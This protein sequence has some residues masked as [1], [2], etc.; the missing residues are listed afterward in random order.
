MMDGAAQPARESAMGLRVGGG[1]G[2]VGRPPQAV[3]GLHGRGCRWDG[4]AAGGRTRRMSCAVA[5]SGPSGHLLWGDSWLAWTLPRSPAGD[6]AR[7]S[8]HQASASSSVKW[9]CAGPAR[10]RRELR[11]VLL[12]RGLVHRRQLRGGCAS[13]WEAS[14]CA[15]RACSGWETSTLRCEEPSVA[16]LPSAPA[17]LVTNTNV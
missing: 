15:G 16:E 13:H 11:E 7:S 8:S 6:P 12:S 5:A 10:W 4:G 1:A 14:G 3:C 9:V 2:G 17:A